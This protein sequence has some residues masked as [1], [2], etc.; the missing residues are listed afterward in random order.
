MFLSIG[1]LTGG[2]SSPPTIATAPLLQYSLNLQIPRRLTTGSGRLNAWLG[3]R[4]CLL[5]N[6]API[7]ILQPLPSQPGHP[8]PLHSI[9]YQHHP[10]PPATRALLTKTANGLP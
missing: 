7:I 6:A 1:W 3:A 10:L 5:N 9:A 4:I 8:P 2:I